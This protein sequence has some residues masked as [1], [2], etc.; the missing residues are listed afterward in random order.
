MKH[1]SCITSFH[2]IKLIYFHDQ[3]IFCIKKCY[4]I[5]Y[6]HFGMTI[7]T[8]GKVVLNIRGIGKNIISETSMPNKLSP[9]TFHSITDSRGCSIQ[10][11]GLHFI[12]KTINFLKSFDCAYKMLRRCNRFYTNSQ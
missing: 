11:F 6:N 2:C 7:P 5:P 1:V 9:D 3:L 4:L 8:G 12:K 10:K